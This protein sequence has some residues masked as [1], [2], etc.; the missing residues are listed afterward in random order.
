MCCSVE[1]AQSHERSLPRPLRASLPA[2][3]LVHMLPGRPCLASGQEDTGRKSQYNS[4]N[5]KTLEHP[6]SSFTSQRGWNKQPRGLWSGTVQMCLIPAQGLLSRRMVQPVKIFRGQPQTQTRKDNTP[7]P[8]VSCSWLGL[9]ST[10]GSSLPEGGLCLFCLNWT[11][12]SCEQGHV[13]SGVCG[14]P[15]LGLGANLATSDHG[16]WFL[17]LVW[18]WRSL[19]S[20][21]CQ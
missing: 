21:V 19:V 14:S 11:C 9:L 5:W 7:E 20:G 8:L 16:L 1:N 18:T 13:G 10:L 3:C 6:T 15:L 2:T 17:G 4:L 12:L